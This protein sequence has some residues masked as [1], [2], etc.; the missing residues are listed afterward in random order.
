MIY[1]L[2]V[3]I[4]LPSSVVW[5]LP[6][7]LYYISGSV[8]SIMF[9]REIIEYINT[10]FK[11]TWKCQKSLKISQEFLS[12]GWQYWSIVP[13]LTSA[14]LFCC[15]FHSWGFFR[16]QFIFFVGKNLGNPGVV[17]NVYSITVNYKYEISLI[18]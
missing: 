3:S 7:S 12:I 10:I 9:L 8:F 4:C 13:S 2:C 6:H 16:I 14:S 17:L 15:H 11:I 18:F 5:L 1:T